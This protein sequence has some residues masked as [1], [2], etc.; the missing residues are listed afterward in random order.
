LQGVTNFVSLLV[1]R[2][3]RRADRDPEADQGR[4]GHLEAR[5][6]GLGNGVGGPDAIEMTRMIGVART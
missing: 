1:N 2:G 3:D 6:D 4:L 5:L